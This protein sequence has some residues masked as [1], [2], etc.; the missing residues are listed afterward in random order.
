MTAPSVW[1]KVPLP[2]YS[3]L[4]SMVAVPFLHIATLFQIYHRPCPDRRAIWQVRRDANLDFMILNE[5]G[6]S[7]LIQ[8]TNAVPL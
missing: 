1:Q 8:D 5:K 7:G 2:T 3:E 4:S 6:Q